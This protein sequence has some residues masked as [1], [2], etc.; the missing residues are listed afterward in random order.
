MAIALI[1]LGFVQGWWLRLA[2][3]ALTGM[4]IWEVYGAYSNLG[5]RP[6][7]WVGVGY[8]LSIAPVY[9]FFGGEAVILPLAAVCLIA[10]FASMILRGISDFK[11]TVA[12]VLP[13]FY[14]GM[15]FS[16]ILPLQDLKTPTLSSLAL[17]MTFLVALMCDVTAYFIGRIWGRHKLCPNISPKKSVEGALAG[18]A[19]A[20]LFAVLSPIVI[21]AAINNLSVFRQYAADLPLPPLWHF[22]ILGALGGAVSQIGDLSASML[23]RHCGI[24]DFGSILPGHGGILDRIDSVLFNAAVVFIYFT[25]VIK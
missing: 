4:S 1:A 7:R 18:L 19:A 16:M 13:I 20:I 12:T 10:G 23:K 21:E 3:A 5:A 22:A 17:L 2:L 11:S 24:K 6:A 8:A 14:P 25:M 15:L 9:A